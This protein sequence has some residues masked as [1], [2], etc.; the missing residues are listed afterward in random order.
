M[1]KKNC[2]PLLCSRRHQPQV[3]LNWISISLKAPQEENTHE[4]KNI[5]GVAHKSLHLD[6]VDMVGLNPLVNLII[7]H[8]IWGTDGSNLKDPDTLHLFHLHLIILGLLRIREVSI[9]VDKC[10]LAIKLRTSGMG[11]EVLIILQAM[12]G[13]STCLKKG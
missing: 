7:I 13:P 4:A 10:P 3:R 11:L 8:H 12:S 2:A 6:N 1:Q 5:P 9:E